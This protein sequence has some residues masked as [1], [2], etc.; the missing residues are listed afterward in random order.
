VKTR[1]TFFSS[2]LLILTLY[3]NG[4]SAC[5]ETLNNLCQNWKLNEINITG[6]SSSTRE[7]ADM[8]KNCRTEFKKDMTYLDKTQESVEKGNWTLDPMC[9]IIIM[10]TED[11][12]K[13]K[14]EVVLLSSDLFKFKAIGPKGEILSSGTF[15]PAK[16]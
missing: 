1:R 8:I 12:K 3:A 13:N 6:D 16:N 5:S 14:F 9:K 11:G 10:T 7:I 4:Q 2:A 15:V